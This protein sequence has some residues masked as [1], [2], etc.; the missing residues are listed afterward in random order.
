MRAPC[1]VD[2]CEEPSKAKGFCNRHYVQDKRYGTPHPLRSPCTEPGC[3]RLAM[4]VLGRFGKCRR[5]DQRATVA[6]RRASELE[7]FN[8][9]AVAADYRLRLAQVGSLVRMAA[10][11]PHLPPGATHYTGTDLF[12]LILEACEGNLPELPAD[13]PEIEAPRD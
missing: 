5:C 11:L 2:G 7:R 1:S 13:L 6:R 9:Y 12:L 8:P 10:L 4:P 3:G